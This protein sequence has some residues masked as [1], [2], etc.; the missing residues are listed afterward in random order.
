MTEQTNGDSYEGQQFGLHIP[1]DVQAALVDLP[2]RSYRPED[3]LWLDRWM[4]SL[5]AFYDGHTPENKPLDQLV[6]A[7]KTDSRGFFTKSKAILVSYDETT[8]NPT[9]ALCLNHKRGGAVKIG[10]V[11]VDTA[12]R[13]RG[14]GKTLFEA[15]DIYAETIGARKLFATT[16]HLNAVVNRLFERYGFGVEATFPDQYKR[17]S[18][19]LIW[20]KFTPGHPSERQD[21][22]EISVVAPYAGHIA[23]IST[24]TEVDRGYIARVNEIYTEWHNDLGDDFI[25]GMTKGHERGLQTGLSFQEKGKIINVAITDSGEPAGMLTYTPKRGGP[26]KLYPL[27]GSVE[28]QTELIDRAVEL[29]RASGNHKLY[30]FAHVEDIT[31]RELLAKQNFIERGTLRSPYKDGNDLVALDRMII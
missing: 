12:L 4:G 19:E 18:Q 9:G 27:A 7:E 30:T 29:A 25:E 16:S 13:G 3:Y 10:P 14:I 23:T 15:A 5:A 11:V 8:G 31:Q 20:G 1:L 28:A 2:I 21:S 6:N 22:L 17:G 26:V 24:Y